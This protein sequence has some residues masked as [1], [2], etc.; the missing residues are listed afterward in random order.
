ME[1]SLSALKILRRLLIV[2]YEYPNHDKHVQKIWGKSQAFLSQLLPMLSAKPAILLSPAKELVE[3]HVLQLSKMHVQMANVHPAAFALLPNSLDLLQAYWG[4]ISMFGDT[5]GSKTQDF[6]AKALSGD[7][8][9]SDKPIQEA[10][11]LKGLKLFRACK[12][13]VLAS[14]ISCLG[15][16]RE[17]FTLET[18]SHAA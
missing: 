17:Q 18:L 14:K 5:Y 6:N 1:N 11:S 9:S 7:G 2:G 12:S 13:G 15:L 4:L 3:K 16:C 10:L 8:S